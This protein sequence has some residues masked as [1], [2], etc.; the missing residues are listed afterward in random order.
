M[1]AFAVARHWP[2]A[3]SNAMSPGWVATKMGGFSASGSMKK[4]IDLATRLST[5]DS[6]ETGSGKYFTT[7]DS[8]NVNAAA[9]DVAKQ[10]QFLK[11]CEE[12]SGVTFPK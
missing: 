5:S 6:K 9:K 2:S 11:I 8:G 4:A 7:Q 1:L 3:T 12:L 10:E